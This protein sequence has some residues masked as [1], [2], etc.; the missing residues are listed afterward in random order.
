MTEN[1]LPESFDIQRIQSLRL[2]R[3]FAYWEGKRGTAKCPWRKDIDPLEIPYALGFILIAEAVPEPEG[4][5]IRL[6]GEEIAER[7]AIDLTGRGLTEYPEPVYRDL[8]RRTFEAV[9]DR[10]HPV[11]V[12]RELV[13]GSRRHRYEGLTLPLTSDGVEIDT[14]VSCLDFAAR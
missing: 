13:V 10:R 7:F 12:Q 8:V 11:L 14:V 2:R 5:H 1:A 9:L 6:M 4:F 3:F